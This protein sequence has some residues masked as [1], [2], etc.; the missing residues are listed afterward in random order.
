M[1]NRPLR[2]RRSV[3]PADRR[4]PSAN[5]SIR[6]GAAA[7]VPAG[8]R[9]LRTHHLAYVGPA[10]FE[11]YLRDGG[12]TL[13]RIDRALAAVSLVAVSRGLLVTLC[14]AKK[15]RGRGVGGRVL[16]YLAPN[17][18]RAAEPAVPFF[19][20]RGYTPIGGWIAGR[21]LRTRVMVRTALIG[22]AGRLREVFGDGE[23]TGEGEQGCVSSP[24]R[25]EA[26]EAAERAAPGDHVRG[27]GGGGAAGVPGDARPHRPATRGQ[28]AD[29]SQLHGRLAGPPRRGRRNA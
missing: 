23:E 29:D 10:M 21:K 20:A 27:D 18:V 24:Y 2:L 16:D 22:L 6:V 19:A 9:F 28:P 12:Y 3:L 7:D 4:L 13:Y 14:V 8:Y 26:G 17:F 15:F 25:N 1:N 5:L 11:R